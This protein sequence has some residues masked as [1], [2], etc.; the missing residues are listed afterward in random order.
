MFQTIEFRREGEASR[1]PEYP[2]LDLTVVRVASDGGGGGK[3]VDN[4]M[5]SATMMSGRNYEP[6]VL[7]DFNTIQRAASDVVQRCVIPGQG[8]G[9]VV[10]ANAIRVAVFEAN[11]KY[12]RVS[13]ALNGPIKVYDPNTPSSSRQQIPN[14]KYNTGA[15]TGAAAAAAQSGRGRK[16]WGNGKKH[17]EGERVYC[18]SG[19][20]VEGGDGEGICGEGWECMVEVFEN[21][22]PSWGIPQKGRGVLDGLGLCVVS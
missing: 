5:I 12:D 8:G 15:G 3:A 16:S 13:G 20:V 21:I 19:G 11:S 14:S 7:E 6:T 18:N 22:D 2:Y 9:F 1:Y 10:V 4:C 17:G